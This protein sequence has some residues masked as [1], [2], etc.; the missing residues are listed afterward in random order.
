[1]FL[2]GNSIS[3][4]H[5]YTWLLAIWKYS[6]QGLLYQHEYQPNNKLHVSSYHVCWSV[7]F[8]L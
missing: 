2:G 1:M 7:S 4:D 3:D 5:G 8:A 6:L